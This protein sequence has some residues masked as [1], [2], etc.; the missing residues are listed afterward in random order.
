LTN[1]IA[2]TNIFYGTF[3]IIV[4]PN[5]AVDFKYYAQ[6]EPTWEE[7]ASIDLDS[8]GNRFF[9]ATNETLPLVNY[10]DQPVT[11][12]CAVSF[13]VDMSVV[14]TEDT[15]FEPSTVVLRGSFNGWN[16][17]IA[18]TN[19]P[20]AANPNLYTA[21]LQEPEG[22]SFQYQFA[23]SYGT[24][25]D[26]I[27]GT[28]YDYPEEIY[29]EQ[30]SAYNRVV[31]IPNVTATNIPNVL[32][33]GGEF[34]DYVSA[35]VNVSFEVNMTPATLQSLT[36]SSDTNSVGEFNPQTDQVYINGPL[37]GPVTS[38]WNYWYLWS[39]GATAET[40]PPGF[41]LNRVGSSLIYSNTF[42]LSVGTP[43]Y[44]EYTYGTDPGGTYGGPIQDEP[45]TGSTISS[46]G[47]F[48]Y[49]AAHVRVIRNTSSGTYNMPVDTFG[50]VYYEPEINALNASGANLTVGSVTNGTVP[51]EWLGRPGAE[52][53]YCTSLPAANW[54]TIAATDGTNWNIGFYGANGFVS[55]TNW[56]LQGATYFRVVK[57]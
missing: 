38:D 40:A 19:N 52:L 28:I 4:S 56:P 1:E 16:A 41:E 21:V 6:P 53:Q 46:F 5:A 25:Y 55:T 34:N 57:H 39:G 17:N 23:Y 22:A 51:I 45:T 37:S 42:T 32:F 35:P 33:D 44:F 7:P 30:G 49:P 24:T 14:A 31:T 11:L 18:C 20:N 47:G 29:G 48:G 54:Q 36:N 50:D 8:G 26:G 2:N 43:V 3:P 27:A 13:N 15:F 12:L 9:A 10:S